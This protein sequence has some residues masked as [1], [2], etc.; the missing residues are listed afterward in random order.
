MDQIN[1]SFFKDIWQNIVAVLPKVLAVIVLI[2]IGW[3]VIKIIS[4]ILRKTLTVANA[5]KYG[6]KLKEVEMFRNVDFK[7]TDVIIKTVKWIVIL[8]LTISAAEILGL[9]MVSNGVGAVIAYLPKLF[10]AIAIFLIGVF[11]ANIVKNGIQSAFK[12]LDITGG[13]VIG[14]IVFYAITI[15][16]GIT[17]LNQAEIDTEIITNNLTIIF[18]SFLLA[19]TIAFGLGSREIVQRLLFG[20]YSRKNLEIGQKIRIGDVKGTIDAIDSIYLVLKNEE[21]KFIYPIKEVNDQIIQIMD[22]N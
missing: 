12:A 15:I 17:S 11:L 4:A 21:G 9:K 13:N 8:F 20:F 19:F 22:D 6:D 3:L 7:V 18:G 10:T 5:D 2:V 1:L 16:I 14:N